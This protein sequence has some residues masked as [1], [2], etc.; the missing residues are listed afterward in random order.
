MH[1]L[2]TA[3]P[4]E[5]TAVIQRALRGVQTGDQPTGHADTPAAEI[6]Q[7]DA[8]PVVP[9]E[10]VQ[11]PS[12]RSSAPATGA[13]AP[14]EAATT[15][16]VRSADTDLGGQFLSRTFT[17]A[18]GQ[19]AY[20]L[21]LPRHRTGAPAPLIVML[22]GCTQ[23][24]DDFAAGT[25]MNALADRHGA[26][27]VYPVQPQSAN[28]SKCWNWF[29]P[30]DQQAGKGE[31]ALIAGIT[32]EVMRAHD[33]DPARVYVAGL[34]AGGAMAALMI[35]RYPSLYAAAGIHSGLPAG[36][37]HDLPSALA[38]M[39]GGKGMPTRK[40]A[41][42]PTLARRPLIVFHGDA[43]H[44]VHM[45]NA[46]QLLAP[47]EASGGRAESEKGQDRAGRAF[48]RKRVTTRDGVDAEQWIV[49][50]APHAWSGGTR[51]GTYTDPTGPNASAEML[52]FFLAHPRQPG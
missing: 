18:S 32:Q 3:G 7:R 52:R 44:T 37:A 20:K 38:A 15:D 13:P 33:I 10:V 41:T 46:T 2:R 19:R 8:R 31:P 24:A 27:V 11:P 26:V 16:A 4:T 12:T 17:G 42:A 6:L 29:K 14:Q 47:F 1:L 28:P 49:H 36:S 9:A 30:T 40:A 35:D 25:G 21:Y 43:D 5:A 48:T 50:G 45:A 34:S 51:A 22:H 39:H 23:D